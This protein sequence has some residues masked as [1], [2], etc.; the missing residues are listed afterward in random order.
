MFTLTFIKVTFMYTK[1]ITN[2]F[3]IFNRV[4]IEV[5]IEVLIEVLIKFLFLG[6]FHL[7]RVPECGTNSSTKYSTSDYLDRRTSVCRTRRSHR[8]PNANCS[9][10]YASSF[11]S[12]T[13]GATD[14]LNSCCPR[15]N[16]RVIPT[17]ESHRHRADR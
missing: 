8:P 16:Q 6:S 1:F 3:T 14:Y 2:I 5:S 10:C 12:Q 13:I 4:S 15:P 17:C 9:C 11:A 7:F